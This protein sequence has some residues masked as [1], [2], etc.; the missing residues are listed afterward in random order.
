V[1]LFGHNIA[2]SGLCGGHTGFQDGSFGVDTIE[3]DI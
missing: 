2:H 1:D 3:F